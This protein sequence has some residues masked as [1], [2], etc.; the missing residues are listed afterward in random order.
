MEK[1]WLE[2][3]IVVVVFAAST[4]HTLAPRIITCPYSVLGDHPPGISGMSQAIGTLLHSCTRE[5]CR[6][7]VLLP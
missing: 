1:R 2:K 7:N 3:K 5:R 4:G 6:P